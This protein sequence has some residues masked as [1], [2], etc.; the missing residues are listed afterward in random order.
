MFRT[1]SLAALL[2]GVVLCV[3]NI[4]N[5]DFTLHSAIGTITPGPN[6]EAISAHM[7]VEIPSTKN[8]GSWEEVFTDKNVFVGKKDVLGNQILSG[9]DPS[10]PKKDFVVNTNSRF[11]FIVT[12]QDNNKKQST[13]TY[14]PYEDTVQQK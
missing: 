12:F 10:H 14:G 9:T 11:S 8:P 5:P 2:A 3:P 6:Y 1:L 13:S 7:K 4:G